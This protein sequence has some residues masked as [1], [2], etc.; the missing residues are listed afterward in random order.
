[1]FSVHWQIIWN[2]F[3]CSWTSPSLG[4]R[5]QCQCSTAHC[6]VPREL[7]ALRET[8]RERSCLKTAETL[9]LHL[10][11]YFRCR[12]EDG[13]GK[14]LSAVYSLSNVQLGKHLRFKGIQP[15]PWCCC[16]QTRVSVWLK[17]VFSVW[18]RASPLLLMR[19]GGQYYFSCMCS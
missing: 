9:G 18:S 11:Q 15:F 7:L 14:F 5:Q 6:R 16:K 13:G 8:E 2:H 17:P 1:M 3:C 10:G 19:K 12:G 4:S